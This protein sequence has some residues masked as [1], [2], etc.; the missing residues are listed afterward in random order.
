MYYANFSTKLVKRNNRLHDLD[1]PLLVG[2]VNDID[3]V[4]EVKEPSYI[5][6][7]QTLI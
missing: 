6:F 4:K 3:D 1:S 5:D 2:N 7:Q